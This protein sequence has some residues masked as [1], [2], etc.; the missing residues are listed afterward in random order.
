MFRSGNDVMKDPKTI[1]NM[2]CKYF[3][4]I[5]PTFA[6]RIPAPEKSYDHYIKHPVSNQSFSMSPPDP[7]EITRIAMSLKLK[8]SYCHD[9]RNSSKL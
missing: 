5:G 3:S 8:N 2:F 6:E 4:E 9:G 7:T 1:S